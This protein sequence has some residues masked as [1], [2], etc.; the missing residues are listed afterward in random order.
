[1]E[2]KRA[3][4]SGL[5]FLEADFATRG[6]RSRKRIRRLTYEMD[7]IFMSVD[8]HTG[9]HAYKLTA[10]GDALLAAFRRPFFSNMCD[11]HG[12]EKVRG[13]DGWIRCPECRRELS[14]DCQ[15]RRFAAHTDKPCSRCHSAPRVVSTNGMQYTLCD[16]CQRENNRAKYERRQG[17][18]RGRIAAGET[19][20][21]QG[22]NERPVVVTPH[23][24]GDRCAAC[25]ARRERMR[26]RREKLRIMR[27]AFKHQEGGD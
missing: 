2:I 17:K 6:Q 22:C 9:A 15:E 25:A 20:I 12:V 14:R 7:L 5:Q 19:L 23:H 13:A 16:K 18:L 21:C 3:H 4:D 26:T 8:Q 27:R 24:V 1:M 10:R 11:K